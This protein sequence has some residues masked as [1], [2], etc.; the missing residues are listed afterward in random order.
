LTPTWTLDDGDGYQ[1]N[2][3]YA[4]GNQFSQEVASMTSTPLSHCAENL[5]HGGI[6]LQYDYGRHTGGGP[7]LRSAPQP[8]MAA[9]DDQGE[10][11]TNY[12]DSRGGS[13]G[14]DA[15]MTTMMIRNIPSRYVEMDVEWLLNSVGLVGAYD[16]VFVPKSL[17]RKAN[18]GYAFVNFTA[19]EYGHEC[20]QR[21]TGLSVH[22]ASSKTIEVLPAHKQRLGPNEPTI[23]AGLPCLAGSPSSV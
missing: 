2:S 4:S 15:N 6:L 10:G 5:L 19:V 11:F 21:L 7:G 17:K 13:V 1:H 9:F 3:T 12:E 8:P 22:E 14:A 18:W 16:W 20:Q 23:S